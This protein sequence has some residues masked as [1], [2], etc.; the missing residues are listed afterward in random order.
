MGLSGSNDF[1]PT[2]DLC[3]VYLDTVGIIPEVGDNTPHVCAA[4]RS[5]C[6]AAGIED[7]CPV[8]YGKLEEDLEYYQGYDVHR[9]CVNEL[10]EM[11]RY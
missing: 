4:C 11:L 10:I 6:D 2:C 1:R 3:G 7:V 9:H 5:L 8:C